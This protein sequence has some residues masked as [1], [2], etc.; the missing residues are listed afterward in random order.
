MV[1]KLLYKLRKRN[2][3][4][5]KAQDPEALK[6]DKLDFLRFKR[7]NLHC[8]NHFKGIVATHILNKGLV[9]LIYKNLFDQ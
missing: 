5:T 3:F 7:R 8:K 2:A 9:S 1:G 4:L 6:G